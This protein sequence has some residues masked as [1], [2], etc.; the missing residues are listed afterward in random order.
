MPT[1]IPDIL[2]K[3]KFDYDDDIYYNM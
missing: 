3:R 2:I 1:Y